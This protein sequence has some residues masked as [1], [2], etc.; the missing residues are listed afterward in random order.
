MGTLSSIVIKQSLIA[1]VNFLRTKETLTFVIIKQSLIAVF[2]L[3][4]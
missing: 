3:L 1:V 4:Q 2:N